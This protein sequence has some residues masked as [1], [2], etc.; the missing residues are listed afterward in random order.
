MSEDKVN[1]QNCKINTDY[2]D[3]CRV[4]ILGNNLKKLHVKYQ[5][6]EMCNY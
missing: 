1:T 5:S 4:V 2:T 6:I 3:Y